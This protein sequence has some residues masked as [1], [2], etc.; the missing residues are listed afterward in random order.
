[1]KNIATKEELLNY[2]FVEVGEEERK[3]LQDDFD[4]RGYC[5]FYFCMGHARRGQFYYLM[6]TGDNVSVYASQ[7]D[8]S[9][10]SIGLHD[11]VMVMVQDGKLI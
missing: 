3:E 2:G 6:I 10:C 5:D 1:M 7:P 4:D 9:G 8:G 11:I